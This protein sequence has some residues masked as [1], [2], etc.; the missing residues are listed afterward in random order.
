MRQG[1]VMTQPDEKRIELRMEFEC[2]EADVPWLFP[3]NVKGRIPVRLNVDGLERPDLLEVW[4][5]GRRMI[6]SRERDWDDLEVID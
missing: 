5:N 4:V 2:Q 3:M 6:P 1:A